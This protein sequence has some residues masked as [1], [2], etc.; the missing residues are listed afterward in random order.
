M[1]KSAMKLLS[2]VAPS[3]AVDVFVSPTCPGG[4]SHCSAG[5]L[6]LSLSW[7]RVLAHLQRGQLMPHI[8]DVA[9]GMRAMYRAPADSAYGDRGV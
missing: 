6:S 7:R 3:L 4:L 8:P 2:T 9:P 1:I 5:P